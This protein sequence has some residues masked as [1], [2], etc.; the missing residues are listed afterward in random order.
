MGCGKPLII[1]EKHLCVNCLT[2]LPFTDYENYPNNPL[3]KL[4]RG[5][6]PLVY[7]SATLFY[8]K[9][10]AVQQLIHQLKYKGNQNI[11]RFIA[12]L[13][14]GQLLHTQRFTVPD[15]IV[16]VPLHPQKIKKRGYNQLDTFAQTL[17]EHY[18]IPVLNNVLVKTQNTESQ[19]KKGKWNRFAGIE[20]KFELVNTV[21]ISNKHLLLVDD[22][23][24]TGA[25][26]EACALE[27]FKAQNVSL[28]IV[29][30]SMS[31]H[32]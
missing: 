5:R 7:A 3:E 21:A 16:E 13:T 15:A 31:S 11:G 2:E 28:S 18:H 19:T 4:F 6:V 20:E 23:I 10:G 29:C 25:T 17:A 1:S 12:Q 22:V 30:M 32:L 24:T 26:I 9:R 8:Q 14:I 27:L